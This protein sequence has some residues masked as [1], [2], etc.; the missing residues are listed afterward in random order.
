MKIPVGTKV[1]ID[2]WDSVNR[3]GMVIYSADTLSLLRAESDNHMKK[4]QYAIVIKSFENFVQVVPDDEFSLAIRNTGKSLSL[5]HN[6]LINFIWNH[7]KQNFESTGGIASIL[8]LFHFFQQ[9]SLN[10]FITLDVLYKI[11]KTNPLPFE[12]FEEEGNLYFILREL[13][14]INDSQTILNLAKNDQVLSITRIHQKTQWPELRIRKTLEYVI[15]KG[16]CK[17]QTSFKDGELYYFPQ[18]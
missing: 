15:K 3:R 8:D 13:E 14:R 4:G 16:Y 5:D 2:L 9:T 11:S 17:V 18:I 7:L 10:S 12:C 1:T 6:I